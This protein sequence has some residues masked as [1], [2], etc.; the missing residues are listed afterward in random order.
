M[1]WVIDTSAVISAV[2]NESTKASIVKLTQESDLIAPASVY[3]EVG[4]ALAAGMKRKR[5]G[6]EQVDEAVAQFLRIPIRLV[7]V[8][9]SD[10]MKIAH[11]LE[12]YAYDAYVL[13]TAKTFGRPLLTLDAGLRRAAIT[14]GLE[15]PEVKQ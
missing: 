1:D 15:A 11:R 8:P 10:A 2:A 13:A 7:D 6:P 4:N 14:M 12:I 3:W 5:F 9:L